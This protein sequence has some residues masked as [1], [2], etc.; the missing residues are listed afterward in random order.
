M[1]IYM[2]ILTKT[3]EKDKRVYEQ[4]GRVA[5]E[6]LAAQRTVASLLDLVGKV[7]ELGQRYAALEER[8]MGSTLSFRRP[9]S[10]PPRTSP[11]SFAASK[12]DTGFEDASYAFSLSSGSSSDGALSF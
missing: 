6:F 2:A 9:P 10:T 7:G 11:P 4:A 3:S 12:R 5:A 1:A 8:V